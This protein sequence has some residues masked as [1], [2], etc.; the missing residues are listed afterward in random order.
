MYQW[1]FNNCGWTMAIMS[2]SRMVRLSDVGRAR[3]LGMVEGGRTQHD[4]ATLFGVSR[5]TISKLMTRYRETHDVKDRPRSGRPSSTTA[6][7]DS[8]IVGLAAR[9]RFVT[10]NAIRA[11]VQRP[12]VSDQTIRN[13]LRAGGF[14]SRRPSKV[15]ART[16][17]NERLRLR[18]CRLRARWTRRNL[19]EVLFKDESRFCLHKN[20]GRI[21]VWRRRGECHAK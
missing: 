4:V 21:Q 20:D 7:T 11:E 13:R 12:I 2:G 9:R 15:P 10:A 17:E 18:W 3:S 8:R 16:A 14:R 6:Q 1:F 19:N 5:C